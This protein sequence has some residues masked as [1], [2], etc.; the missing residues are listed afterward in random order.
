MLIKWYGHSCFQIQVESQSVVIDPYVDGS[1]AGYDNL[2]LQA[3]L[4]LCSH[5][6]KDHCGVE[7]VELVE[8]KYDS[9]FKVDTIDSYHDNKNGKLRGN[10][11]IHILTVCDYYQVVHLG[12]LGCMLTSQQIEKIK[13]CHVLM[14]PV[15]GYYTIDSSQAFSLV[16]QIQP[17]VIIPMHYYDNGRDY[18][19]LQPVEKFTAHFEKVLYLTG[20]VLEYSDELEN[21]VVVFDYNNNN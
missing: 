16:Q 4:V 5:M 15:G 18:D 7:N 11:L 21:E 19:L 9:P 10:N 2:R 8:S 12:D 13:N 17:R 6:H 3:N 1:V 20:N 14:I